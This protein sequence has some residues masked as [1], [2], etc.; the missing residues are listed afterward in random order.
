M[1]TTLDIPD[2]LYE[3]IQARTALEG[4]PLRS[5]AVQLFQR[6]L[7]NGPSDTVSP[8]PSPAK[9]EVAAQQN[10]ALPDNIQ[11]QANR[12]EIAFNESYG[13]SWLAITQR[14]IR[15]GMRHDME[16]IREAIAR[17]W[18]AEAAEEELN[19]T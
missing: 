12:S 16:H 14:H 3:R 18:A 13:A 9:P 1:Q 7:E 15:P 19:R 8:P 10:A 4:R 2:D 5:V 6:W 17:G 11:S